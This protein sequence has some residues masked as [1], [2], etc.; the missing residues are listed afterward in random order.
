MLSVRSALDRIFTPFARRMTR[1]DPNTLTFLS[2]TVG[3]LS[4]A[5]FA[6]AHLS[7]VFSLLAAL[8]VALSGIADALDG[9][10][11]RLFARSTPWGDFLDHFGDR[12]TEVAVLAGL[13]ISPHAWHDVAVVVVVLTLLHS[14]L[15]TQWEVSFGRRQYAGAGKA[16]QFFALI[17]I[18]V[19]LWQQ[20][21]AGLAAFGVR[22]ALVNLFL[23]VLGVATA[24][25]IVFRLRLA[26]RTA[27]E[28]HNEPATR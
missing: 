16:E 17:A 7:P 8:L 3:V 20:P 13:G 19:L 27:S 25:A 22:I 4:G 1:V 10:V 21:N 5:S 6:L 12:V 14:Y 15:G 11:A 23:I 26:R 24:G 9:I 28:S 18:G 2:I